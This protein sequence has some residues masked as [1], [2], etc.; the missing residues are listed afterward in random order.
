MQSSDEIKNYTITPR[1]C[2]CE[3]LYN[4]M[5]PLKPGDSFEKMS[6]KMLKFDSHIKKTPPSRI[7]N[8]A[9]VSAI[10]MLNGDD[11]DDDSS[12][13]TTSFLSSSPTVMA[14]MTS[15]LVDRPEVDE[16]ELHANSLLIATS[17]PMR[18]KVAVESYVQNILCGVCQMHVVSYE[19]K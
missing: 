5:S 17:T 7:K 19:V 9:V 18:R 15:S 13:R 1:A 8:H 2:A 3:N 4:G 12:S 6:Q 16:E 11:D 14:L 10:S